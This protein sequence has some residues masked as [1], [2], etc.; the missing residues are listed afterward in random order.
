M[1]TPQEEAIEIFVSV[2]KQ[3]VNPT[4]DLKAI[5]LQCQHACELMGWENVRDWF[6]NEISGYKPEQIPNYRKIYGNTS[7]IREG[8]SIISNEFL[9]ID[10]PEEEIKNPVKEIV[11]LDVFVGIDRILLANTSGYQETTDERR[12]K[13]NAR[14]KE[15][16]FIRKIKNYPPGSFQPIIN[17]I[18]QMTYNLA[19]QSYSTLKFGNAITDIW[20]QYRNHVEDALKKMNLFSHLAA[21]ENGLR[22]ENPEEWR[23]VGYHCRDLLDDLANILWQDPRSEYEHLEGEKGKLNVSRGNTKNRLRAYLHQKGLTRTKG[24]YLS[25]EMERISDSVR[26][27]YEFQCS[28]H[29]SVEK[30]DSQSIA[31]GTF[32]IIGELARRT[33]LEPVITYQNPNYTDE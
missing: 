30:I 25:T 19:S 9:D 13:Y 24:K 21:I 31:L 28:A 15:K 29:G 23:V 10:P 32:Y 11:D 4:H 2:I 26:A 16:Y 5:L 20:S 33:D 3:L 1:T 18:E 8:L 14:K 12:E 17:Y 27:L 22:S 7:W 6:R